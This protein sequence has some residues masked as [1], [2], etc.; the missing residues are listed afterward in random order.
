MMFDGSWLWGCLLIFFICFDRVVTDGFRRDDCL[1]GVDG[2][3]GVDS[4]LGGGG[5]DSLDGD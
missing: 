2:L 3:I 5:V 1:D 4:L